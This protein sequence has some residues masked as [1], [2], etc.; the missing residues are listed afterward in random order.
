MAFKDWFKFTEKAAVEP[1]PAIA[2]TRDSFGNVFGMNLGRSVAPNITLHSAMETA[3]VIAAVKEISEKVATTP[4][5]VMQEYEVDGLTMRRIAKNHWAHKL[6]CR[7][8]ARPNNWQT[9]QQFLET[10]MV[11]A[12]LG[13][14]ALA[15][16]TI[17]GEGKRAKVTELIPVP[18][19]VWTVIP[20]ADNS[21]TFQVT[22]MDGK[23]KTYAHDEVVYFH[24]ISIDGYH[25][26]S[27]VE[28]ARKAVGISNYLEE[29]QLQLASNG[30]NPS[31]ILSYE[32]ELGADR[33]QKISEAWKAAY[34]PGGRGGIA[35]LDA[36]TS[37]SAVTMSMA[38]SQF[39]ENRKF[40]IEEVARVFK[41]QPLFLGH[42]G[43]MNPD[44]IDAAMRFHV[45]NCLMPW[46]VRIE[47]AFTNSLLFADESLYF[48]FDDEDLLRGD[49]KAQ[50]EAYTMGMGSGGI[51][52]IF[53]PNDALEA[54]GKNPI[55][56]DWAKTPMKGAYRQS[57]EAEPVSQPAI[58]DETNE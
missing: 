47:Q 54:L 32:G 49:L 52:G 34:G 10:M 50:V 2:I 9:T 56:E 53:S 11:N 37:F 33:K 19:G 3:A 14:G 48:D 36:G 30:G 17:V 6:L 12:V 4:L 18:N 42:Q 7:K 43:G 41:I 38:D 58:T 27:M 26:L 21:L 44:G 35:V 40:Q 13:K 45:K 20:M 57:A 8:G 31:G 15:L 46:F 29:Q 1:A 25:A 5:R 23:T 16:K 24:G 51:D 28:N 22:T 55:N 39:I